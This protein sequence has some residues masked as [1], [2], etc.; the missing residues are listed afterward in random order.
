MKVVK[1][2]IIEIILLI[3]F[4]VCAIIFILNSK[5]K[6]K[7]SVKQDDLE[8]Q[9][10]TLL[11]DEGDNTEEKLYAEQRYIDLNLFKKYFV[12]PINEPAY[13]L[14]SLAYKNVDILGMGAKKVK[15]C[16]SV[17][18]VSIADE[19][20]GEHIE[21]GSKFVIIEV[22]LTNE[23]ID[24][25]IMKIQRR[26][27]NWTDLDDYQTLE[28][29][30]TPYKEEYSENCDKYGMIMDSVNNTCTYVLTDNPDDYN[31]ISVKSGESITYKLIYK[32]PENKINNSLVFYERLNR[33][34][35]SNRDFV[36]KLF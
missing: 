20:N 11:S 28:T 23:Y 5:S 33:K 32:I 14:N 17:T 13:F 29:I 24:E 2:H 26:L 25:R 18:G 8:Q 30:Y 1:K 4:V 21:T 22:K 6:E 7:Q 31:G 9:R 19:Y 36:I 34:N 15:D 10:A 27:G 12:K 35:A 3:M 16:I